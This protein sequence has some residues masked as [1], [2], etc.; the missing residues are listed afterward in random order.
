[1]PKYTKKN[2]PPRS[3]MAKSGADDCA[4]IDDGVSLCSN[5]SDGT[6]IYDDSEI[7]FSSAPDLIISSDSLDEKLDMSIEGLRNKDSRT[8]E[9]SLRTLQ[10]LFS[11]KYIYDLVSSRSEN[12]TEQL[13]T[14]L[15]KSN[16]SE[17]RLA[18]IVTS[19]FVIQLG[20]TSDELYTKFRDAIMPILR[21]E[22]K[23]SVLRKHFA[24]AIGIICFIACEDISMTIE[25]M[26]TLETIFSRSYLNGDGISPILN[27]DLQDLHTAALSSWCLLVSTMPSNLAHE[28]VRIYAPEKIP[29]L[30]ESN[31]AELRN[32]AGEAVA[33]LYEIARDIKSIF[34]EPPESLLLILEKKA[35]ESAKYKG[36]KEKRLQHATFREIYNSFEEGTS[37]EFD[38]KFG[39]E[40]L[41]ITSW[42]TRLYYNTLS[43]ILAA[44]VNVHLKENGFLRSIF[45][46]DELDMEEIQQSKGNRFERQLANR[47]AFKIRTQALNK[48]RAN[49]VTR[50][51]YDD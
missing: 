31:H 11:Q 25:L 42:T 7:G 19:L 10:A 1:M 16:E 6:S 32:Q 46:L 37:P 48:T 27:H 35:N 26:K 44:G 51:Q 43:S 22:S 38:V 49:K 18:A 8:R 12:L 33:I 23:S 5:I 24:K 21:D 41:E 45:N 9:D 34:A 30:I 29:G 28:L 39:R 17:G 20:E 40:V 50:S 47:S 2:R 15:R 4:S 14:C 13:A 36:K 3:T